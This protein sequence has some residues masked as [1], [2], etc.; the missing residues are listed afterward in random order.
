MLN[1]WIFIFGLLDNFQTNVQFLTRPAL[2]KSALRCYALA[3]KLELYGNPNTPMESMFPP[4]LQSSP[5]GPAHTW[6]RTGLLTVERGVVSC[7]ITQHHVILLKVWPAVLIGG[8]TLKQREHFGFVSWQQKHHRSCTHLRHSRF[9]GENKTITGV[10][11]SRLKQAKELR[12]FPSR[13]PTFI[14]SFMR[15]II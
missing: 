4:M 6:R 3:R 1:T 2:Y 7:R 10:Q 9:W 12:L 8:M 5:T 13:V 11:R 15:W 14:S